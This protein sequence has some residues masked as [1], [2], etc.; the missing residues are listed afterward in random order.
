ML[1]NLLTQ[2]GGKYVHDVLINSPTFHRIVRKTHDTVKGIKA[3]P[4]DYD[5]HS[6]TSLHFQFFVLGQ[7][8]CTDGIAA[9]SHKVKKFGTIFKDEL[10]DNFK[11]KRK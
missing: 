9:I 2:L 7:G 8:F 3:A 4:H 6:S 5:P 11:G 1:R 10:I